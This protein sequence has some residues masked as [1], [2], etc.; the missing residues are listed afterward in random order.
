MKVKQLIAKLQKVDGDIEIMLHDGFS[1]NATE[2]ESI[3]FD[4]S[5]S[6]VIIT[7]QEVNDDELN[8]STVIL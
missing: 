2:I 1:L 6:I 4:E 8:D 7:P 5:Q 3:V